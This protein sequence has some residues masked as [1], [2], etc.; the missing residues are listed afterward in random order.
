MCQEL[1]ILQIDR[2]LIDDYLIGQQFCKFTI[3]IYHNLMKTNICH[4]FGLIL[5]MQLSLVTI[6]ADFT[7]FALSND[8]DLISAAQL[9]Q[10]NSVE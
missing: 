3:Y 4:G 7:L 9:N 8:F 1:E 6:G 10:Y 5:D 2:S